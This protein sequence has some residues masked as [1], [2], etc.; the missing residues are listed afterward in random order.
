MED[1]RRP[2]KAHLCSHLCTPGQSFQLV[3]CIFMLHKPLDDGVSPTNTM[4]SS[5]I[6][7]IST[8]TRWKTG[9]GDWRWTDS[10]RGNKSTADEQAIQ[11]TAVNVYQCVLHIPHNVDSFDQYPAMN[12]TL[13]TCSHPGGKDRSVAQQCGRANPAVW[14]WIMGWQH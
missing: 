10:N 1:C 2:F 13:Q 6:I 4:D 8:A 11:A 9:E 7:I 14:C 12:N 5:I 3:C